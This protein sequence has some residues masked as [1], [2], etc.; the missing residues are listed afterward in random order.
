MSSHYSY[1]NPES[2]FAQTALEMVAS[3][4]PQDANSDD[5]MCDRCQQP[6]PCP[7]V[8]NAILVL[9]GA[10]LAVHPAGSTEARRASAESAL[11]RS[12]PPSGPV[13]PLGS[14]LAGSPADLLGPAGSLPLP[15]AT[16][17]AEASGEPGADADA[18][19]VAA[20]PSDGSPGWPDPAAPRAVA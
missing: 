4:G 20:G 9:E 3:H 18:E 15:D 11:G 10:G 13:S 2:V 8:R 19:K 7:P 5:T 16:A 12:L 6:L 14:P 17:T 1:I